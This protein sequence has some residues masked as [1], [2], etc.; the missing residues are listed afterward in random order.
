VVTLGEN[1]RVMTLYLTY[2][3]NLSFGQVQSWFTGVYNIHISDGEISEILKRASQKLVT[4]YE[5]LKE[6]IRKDIGTHL[7]ESSWNGG[8]DSTDNFAWVM[9]SVSSS[10]TVFAV[11]KNRGRA[12]AEEL[13][14]KDFN[15][16]FISDCYG[17]YKNLNAKHQVCWAHILRY[18]R[19]LYSVVQSELTK[20]FYTQVKE[21][22]NLVRQ[23]VLLD[24]PTVMKEKIEF[25][26]DQ[27]CD[28]DGL[29]ITKTP[30]K[31]LMLKNRLREYKKEFLTCLDNPGIPPDNNKA[32]RHLRHII[33]K[34]KSCF[35]TKTATGSRVF[36]VNASVVLS[37]WWREK[38]TFF[39]YVSG[40]LQGE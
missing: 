32:E 23:A 18:S 9:T 20:D 40:L 39:P 38:S 4:P 27:L 3:M 37:A 1:I 5:Q 10:D 25:C 8:P 36:E 13:L 2:V 26:Y 22:Y 14:G 19:E 12:N 11:G 29:N 7:D 35:G 33:L 16:V 24:K 30:K 28:Q 17:G 15:G 21:C 31:L 6:K 34:R